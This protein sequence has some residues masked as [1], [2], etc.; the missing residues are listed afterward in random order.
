MPTFGA[1]CPALK[2]PAH[3]R[4]CGHWS[5]SGEGVKELNIRLL[6][7]GFGGV[8]KYGTGSNGFAE[9]IRRIAIKGERSASAR[10]TLQS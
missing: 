1:A 6:P 5:A 10:T 4:A 2:R 9:V 3:S 7:S 8:E